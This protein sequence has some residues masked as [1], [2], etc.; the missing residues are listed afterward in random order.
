MNKHYPPQLREL[1]QQLVI[2]AQDG[3]AYLTAA[4]GNLAAAEATIRAAYEATLAQQTGLPPE[5]A[6]LVLQQHHYDPAKALRAVEDQRLKAVEAG[7]QETELLLKR[8]ARYPLD[9]LKWVAG[10]IRRTHAL[11]RAPHPSY[12][13]HPWLRLENL[14]ALNPYQRSLLT[15]MEWLDYEDY[16]GLGFALYFYLPE[17]M[18]ALESKL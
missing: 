12:E 15:I 1:R 10:A 5:A 18:E 8:H 11:E 2:G 16:E 14:E 3:L 13:N 4:Q 17:V 9:A 7:Y 6:R